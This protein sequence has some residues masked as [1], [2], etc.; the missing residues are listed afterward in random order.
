MSTYKVVDFE[1]QIRPALKA[2]PLKEARLSE[3]ATVLKFAKPEWLDDYLNNRLGR[4]VL[5]NR[6][7]D[8]KADKQPDSRKR[9]KTIAQLR[10]TVAKALALGMNIEEIAFEFKGCS[11]QLIAKLP[12][13]A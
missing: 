10:T 7:R 2:I 5:V 3:M 11:Y 12:K 6:A 9:Q 13:A 8:I 4:R 1:T